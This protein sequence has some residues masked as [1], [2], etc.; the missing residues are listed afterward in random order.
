MKHRLAGIILII[1]SVLLLGGIGNVADS[2]TSADIGL[3][4]FVLVIEVGLIVFWV[5]CM[6]KYHSPQQATSINSAVSQNV[7][8]TNSPKKEE[9]TKVNSNT[10]ISNEKKTN[11]PA[12]K[13]WWFWLIIVWVAS[14][15]LIGIMGEVEDDTQNDNT[16]IDVDTD[17]V[18]TTSNQEGS[19]SNPYV[20]NAVEWYTAHR[21]GNATKK[22]IDQWVKISGMVLSVSDY[23]S[24]KGYYLC[25]GPGSGLVCWVEGESVSVQYGQQ[26]EY[27]G[28]VTVEDSKQIELSDGTI[29]NVSW[30]TEK[31]KSPITISEWTW[32]RDSAGG[33]EWDFRFTNNTDKTVKYIVMEWYC[34]N[35]VGDLVYDEISRK[36]SHGI[37]FTGSLEAGKTSDL[38]CNSTLFYNHS[39][40]TSKLTKL[41]V[42]FMDGTVIHINDEA[43]VDIIQ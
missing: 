5:R 14:G 10:L 20:L 26:I 31:V 1:W 13:Q 27:V 19:Q 24:L 15:M 38:M 18:D 7:E 8:S 11:K 6:N 9:I 29:Q 25:G 28:K 42:E 30:P 23:G 41:T 36:A 33:V 12:Y 2:P 21:D 3:F 22:Y 4:V 43:Y 32:T 37:K 35:A 39:Y 17:T 16:E 34:Y 40:H